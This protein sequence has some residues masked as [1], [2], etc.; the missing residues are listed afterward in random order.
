MRIAGHQAI[1]SAIRDRIVAGEWKLGERIPDE[2][3]FAEE[4]A[5]SRTTVNRAIQALADEGIV[6]RKRKGGTRVRPLPLRVA[7]FPI[8]ILR[9]QV[10][11]RGMAYS[12]RVA[13]RER[14][15]VPDA[16]AGR[17]AIDDAPC[18]YL[19]TVH[20]ADG[21]P[22]AFETRWVNLE[23]VPAFESADFTTISANEWLVRTVPFTRGEIGLS[24]VTAGTSLALALDVP[25]GSALLAME[26][27]T[28]FEDRSVTTMTLYHRPDHRMEFEI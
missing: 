6:E 7:Q 5:C 2:A 22:F 26:R 4:F 14:R 18:L 20:L 27:V 28:W 25:E 11:S 16:V 10:E 19:E 21:H 17:M 12:S 15:P 1:R 24:A 8:P 13:R 9:A 3:D 23:T